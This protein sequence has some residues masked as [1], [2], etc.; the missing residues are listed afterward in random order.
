[1]AIEQGIVIKMGALGPL[2]TAWVKTT[3]SSA[4]ESCASRDQCNPGGDGKA[5]EVEAINSAGARVG[6]LI[7]LSIRTSTMLK[8]L[9]LLYLFP[10]LCMLAGGITGDWV[11]P[12]FNANPSVVATVAAFACFAVALMIVRICGQR[13]GRS[14]DYRPKIIRILG[15]ESC[16]PAAA[17]PVHGGPQDLSHE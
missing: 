12:R 2:A 5:H 1:M 11:A 9:F 4:C 14:E 10:I 3:R 6:D 16:R 7:Q 8:A 15:H 13:M 17:A